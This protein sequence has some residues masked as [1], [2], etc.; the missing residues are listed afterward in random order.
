M[1][2]IRQS[3]SEVEIDLRRAR[4]TQLTA[5]DI[6]WTSRQPRPVRT[7]TTGIL[8]MSAKIYL[9]RAR[10]TCLTEPD[11]QATSTGRNQHRK[12]TS[13]LIAGISI[14]DLKTQ[15]YLH[16]VEPNI[17]FPVVRHQHANLRGGE[18]HNRSRFWIL[19]E[20]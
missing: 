19:Y 14:A 9:R 16:W 13:H 12:G 8:R 7:S 15:G 3:R 18:E 1:L 11:R 5:P 4:A 10:A 6:M 17:A 20:I 2:H